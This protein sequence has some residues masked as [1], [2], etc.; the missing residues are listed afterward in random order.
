M[1]ITTVPGAN[2]PRGATLPV[3]ERL[4]ALIAASA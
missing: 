3:Q 2:E 1:P 4:R